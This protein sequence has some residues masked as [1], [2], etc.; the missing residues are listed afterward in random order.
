MLRIC[1]TYCSEIFTLVAQPDGGSSNN[2]AP[3]ASQALIVEVSMLLC[4]LHGKFRSAAL[5]N[6]VC[7]A[8][9]FAAILQ[10]SDD[11]V[12]NTL[13]GSSPLFLQM[14]QPQPQTAR[15]DTGARPVKHLLMNLAA[16]NQEL[17]DDDTSI[18]DPEASGTFEHAKAAFREAA[19]SAT[20]PR[21]V[22]ASVE[23]GEGL[24]MVGVSA[25]TL[26]RPQIAAGSGDPDIVY[27][28]L[29]GKTFYGTDLK[30]QEYTIDS[31]L[32]MQWVDPRTI[33]MVPAGQDHFTLADGDSIGTIWTPGIN[34]TNGAGSR[35]DRISSSLTVTRDGKVTQVDE[36]LAVVKTK[37]ILNNFPFDEQTLQLNVASMQYMLNEVKLS[38]ID[39]IVYS[40]L[41]KG[42]FDGSEYTESS[43][44]VKTYEDI[45][46]PLKKSRGSMEIGVTRSLFRFQRNFLVP[47]FLYLAISCAVFW[48]P[49]SPTYV[50]PRVALS[51]FILLIFANLAANADNELPSSAPYNWKD[52][53]CF[54]IQLQMF[55][56]VCLNILI[57]I[58]YHSMKCTV[59]ATHISSELKIVAPLV[60]A[61]SM[62]IILVAATTPEAP[63]GLR[64][65]TLLM[66]VMFFLFIISYMTCCASTLSAEL[67]RNKRAESTKGTNEH[68]GGSQAGLGPLASSESLA[69]RQPY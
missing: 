1:S 27:F 48:L 65:M 14:R 19:H 68:H 7:L 50:T 8:G 4:T 22:L 20:V 49:F 32:T 47:A 67:K 41:R 39:E 6:T 54:T 17:A 37:F 63:L 33:A 38:P 11:A 64:G 53:L 23:G 62:T 69:P 59:T 44:T 30:A 12:P 21:G 57:E 60:G 2:L 15:A 9:S 5:L 18:A 40:G 25:T 66:P 10:A 16:I 55:I 31:I 24:H 42:F 29:Y 45:D 43:F 3:N 52:L 51:I 61:L 35:F 36:V 58:A 26:P 56:V 46:G 28:G 13:E 34:I